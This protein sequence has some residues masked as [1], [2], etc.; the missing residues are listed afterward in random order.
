MLTLSALQLRYG[1]R[2]ELVVR[3]PERIALIGGNGAGKTTLLRTVAGEIPPQS[4]E[5]R[6]AVPLRYLPQRLSLLDDDLTVIQNVRGFAPSA[7]DNEARARLARFLF[8]GRR[9]DQPVGTLSGGERF[10]ATFAAP[11][12][13][14]PAPQLLLLDEPTNNLDLA[15]ARQLVVALESYRGALIVASHDLAFLGDL[16][17]TRWLRLDGDLDQVDPPRAGGSVP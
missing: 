10:R 2:A 14:Q 6:V 13:A 1:A 9:A 17:I 12:L 4:G 15:S 16:G 11:L 7:S 5:A 8:Q 3:G